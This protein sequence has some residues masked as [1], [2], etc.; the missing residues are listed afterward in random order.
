MSEKTSEMILDVISPESTLVHAAVE[1]VEL[2]GTKGRFE[3]LLD[4]AP[5]ISSLE[6]GVIAYRNGEGTDKVAIS[7][8]FVE[9]NDNH[10]VACVEL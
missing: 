3:V 5:L 2:P 9:V 10:V 7:S 8:G 1:A 6:K 4:H